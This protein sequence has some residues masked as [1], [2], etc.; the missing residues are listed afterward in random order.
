MKI[1]LDVFKYENKIMDVHM[2]PW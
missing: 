2:N 1:K